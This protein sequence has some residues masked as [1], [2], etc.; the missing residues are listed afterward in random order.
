MC[1]TMTE[2]SY[3]DMNKQLG[4]V[5]KDLSSPVSLNISKPTI[6]GS[7]SQVVIEPK[8]EVA[9]EATDEDADYSIHYGFHM[10][11]WSWQ[12]FLLPLPF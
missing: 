6:G 4:K 12:N 3:K 10:T 11:W 5:F 8:E 9:F 2:L 7:S 1:A